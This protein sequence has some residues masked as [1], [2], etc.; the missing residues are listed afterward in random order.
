[1]GIRI[2]KFL[3]YG[4]TDVRTS[5]YKLADD[6]FNPDSPVF[7][8]EFPELQEYLEWLEHNVAE[9]EI[10]LDRMFVNEVLKGER[11]ARYLDD[12]FA[13]NTEFGKSNVMAFQPL[14]TS[15]WSRYDDTIDWIEESE[16][17][18]GQRNKVVRLRHGIYPWNGLYMDAR[19]G[20]RLP[21]EIMNWIRLQSRVRDQKRKGKDLPI[22]TALDE[23]AKQAGLKDNDEAEAVVAPVIPNDIRN[24]V[25]FLKVFKDPNGYLT[26]RPLLYT[27]WS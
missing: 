19:T 27:Y 5:G 14:M 2:H 13:F 9:D 11:K 1:M 6:R 10:D 23:A 12:T 4:L 8:Y 24:I 26:L 18:T 20:E 16:V 7:K 22:P 17:R 3:G 21:H 15:D 25:N